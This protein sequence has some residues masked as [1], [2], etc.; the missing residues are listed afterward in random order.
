MRNCVLGI[1]VGVGI[2]FG[3]LSLAGA[4]QNY[5]NKQRV[6]AQV[7]R[8]IESM[9]VIKLPEQPAK[10]YEI[11]QKLQALDAFTSY[12]DHLIDNLRY[13]A[14]KLKADAL[15]DVYCKIVYSRMKACFG[16]A[17]RYTESEDP[18]K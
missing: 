6:S 16:N 9:P 13:Q 17:I 12:E 14:G 15:S 10:K 4:G 8:M 18:A 1:A 3:F 7:E 5:T 11:L 2:A